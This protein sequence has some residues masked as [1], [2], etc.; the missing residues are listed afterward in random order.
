MHPNAAPLPVC[1]A[2]ATC[3]ECHGIAP[4]CLEFA[5]AMVNVAYCKIPI[6]WCITYRGQQS[7]KR[8]EEGY[9][10]I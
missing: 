7:T 3:T 8:Y 10:L 4:M 9:T 1:V 6:A 2:I 5:S